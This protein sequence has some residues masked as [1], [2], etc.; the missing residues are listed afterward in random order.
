MQ[1]QNLS[2]EQLAGIKKQFDSDIESLTHMA[3]SLRGARARFSDSKVYLENLKS[4]PEGTESLIPLSSSLY[5]SG[6]F[7]N[8]DKVLVDVG[9]GYFINQ[10]VDRAQKYF[11]ARVGQMGESMDNINKA[12][13]EKVRVQNQVI[14]FM[15]QKAQAMQMAQQAQGGDDQK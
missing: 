6:T 14:E 15:Q 4:V 13:N 2:L 12:I 8:R 7:T 9:T 5:V 3:E 10:G 1:L 11:D